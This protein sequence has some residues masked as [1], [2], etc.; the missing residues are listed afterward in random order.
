LEFDYAP[1]FYAFFAATMLMH[2][3]ASM[4]MYSGFLILKLFTPLYPHRRALFAKMFMCSSALKTCI[5]LC[6]YVAGWWNYRLFFDPRTFYLRD[7]STA[8]WNDSPYFLERMSWREYLMNVPYSDILVVILPIIW[9]FLFISQTYNSWLQFTIGFYELRV[10]KA[11]ESSRTGAVRHE[12][13]EC[14]LK[15][16][17]GGKDEEQPPMEV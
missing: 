6:A 7:R 9:T 17:R 3:S 14:G 16:P 12:G 5:M 15:Q 4:F 13:S 10:A 8:E 1:S 11:E 2:S